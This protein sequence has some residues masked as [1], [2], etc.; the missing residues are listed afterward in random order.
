[1]HVNYQ[2]LKCDHRFVLEISDSE[3]ASCLDEGRAET[4]PVCGQRIGTGPVRCRRCGEGFELAFRHWYVQC[5]VASGECPACHERY[6][7][8]CIC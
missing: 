5:D 1:M 6:Q 4:C 7:S 3:A 2:C 8:L